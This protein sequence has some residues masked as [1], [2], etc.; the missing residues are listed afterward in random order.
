MTGWLHVALSLFLAGVAHA[1]GAHVTPEPPKRAERPTMDRAALREQVKV[2]L[3]ALKSEI[4]KERMEA[5]VRGAPA[6]RQVS[7]AKLRESRAERTEKARPTVREFTREH[8]E[9]LRELRRAFI[10]RAQ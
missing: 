5:A 4:R 7:V 8:R 3:A 9:E 6:A 10:R 1:E 2:E